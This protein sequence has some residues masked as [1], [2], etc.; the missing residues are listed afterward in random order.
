MSNSANNTPYCGPIDIIPISARAYFESHLEEE[1]VWTPPPR[2][3]IGDL[4]RIGCDD[5]DEFG[6]LIW[7]VAVSNSNP[8]G[9]IIVKINNK[10][11]GNYKCKQ[12][13]IIP[14]LIY[15]DQ[16][17]DYIIKYSQPDFNIEKLN[18][19]CHNLAVN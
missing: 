11:R 9:S 1:C 19:N 4:I 12:G 2:L 6:E 3:K 7:C 17:F 10:V 5:Y 13:D 8:D 16:M 14:A 18:T 15:P